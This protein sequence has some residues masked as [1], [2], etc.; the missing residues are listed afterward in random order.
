[1]T[2]IK[3]VHISDLHFR[4]N[5]DQYD[6]K[7]VLTPLLKSIEDFQ[8]DLVF[9]TGDIGYY[10]KK[11]D[12]DV[13]KDFFNKLLNITKFEHEDRIWIVPG[14]H[15]VERNEFHSRPNIQTEEHSQK[16]FGNP[17]SR[18]PHL[19]KFEN[20]KNFF[21][22]LFPHQL[23]LDGDIVPQPSVVK[24]KDFPIGI[25]PINSAFLS[26]DDHDQGKLWIGV[27][28]VRERIEYLK[29]LTPCPQLSIAL[30]HHPF[31]F[32]H[33]SEEARAWLHNECHIILIGHK[34][35]NNIQ[36]VSSPDGSIIEIQAGAA[37]QG[38]NKQ[39]LCFFVTLDIKKWEIYLNPLQYIDKPK[40][41]NWLIQ[42]SVF[43]EA[44][45]HIGVCNLPPPAPPIITTLNI[46]Y[47]NNKETINLNQISTNENIFPFRI[48]IN[49]FKDTL[50]IPDTFK[51]EQPHC[52]SNYWDFLYNILE[53]DLKK[54]TQD[55]PTLHSFFIE[56]SPYAFL[57]SLTNYSHS[58]LIKIKRTKNKFSYVS[59]PTKSSSTKVNINSLPEHPKNTLIGLLSQNF[60]DVIKHSCQG[61]IFLPLDTN[62]KISFDMEL[63]IN[64]E[65]I[66]KLKENDAITNDKVEFLANNF[67]NMVL[68]TAS[69]RS[70]F[71]QTN[72]FIKD[73]FSKKDIETI[74]QN[75]SYKNRVNK[76]SLILENKDFI[77]TVTFSMNFMATGL[78][79]SHP[80]F[81]VIKSFNGYQKMHDLYQTFSITGEF[82]TLFKCQNDN[83]LFN[84]YKYYAKTIKDILKNEWDYDRFIKK[85]PH[86]KLYVIENYLKSIINKG[87]I[88][89]Y[90]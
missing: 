12:Y 38:S 81:E 37:Y 74:F 15:D 36:F 44:T 56:I 84:D 55:W 32:L 31:D 14:N 1:M 78:E 45:N 63:A 90:E 46:K 10:G 64:D 20:Y 35:R 4:G 72:N 59:L 21:K 76:S 79:V 28:T 57:R 89:L 58:W 23:L 11:E 47:K 54:I 75:V 9:V 22:E 60:L 48:V 18:K 71:E 26:K 88:N 68:T 17:E 33:D 42:P 70:I 30:L 39:C 61:D 41:K 16:F 53:N 65:T 77:F 29:R 52:I 86:P 6:Y 43:P 40:A 19:C 2:Q 24:I 87:V 66:R 25:L 34:H 5:Q 27:R 13:S 8:P 62:L 51:I 49:Y 69:L 67:N 82:R 7:N 83:E 73:F 80:Y 50:K 85:L 3:W